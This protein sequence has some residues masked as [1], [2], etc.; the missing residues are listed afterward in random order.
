MSRQILQP[1]KEGA[2]IN[3]TL[4]Q[5]RLVSEHVV[6]A[7]STPSKEPKEIQLRVDTSSAFSVAL[8]DMTGPKHIL[9]EI[10]YKVNLKTQDTDKQLV[11]YEAKHVAQLDLASWLGF[12]DW[13]DVPNGAMAPYLA[14]IQNIAMRRAEGTLVDMGVRGINLPVSPVGKPDVSEAKA[15]VAAPT[16]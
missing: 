3:A 6:S 1:T 16:K 2:F 4:S 5:T 14:M 9:V 13:T 10:V 11:E 8:D 7:P 15:E 12:D